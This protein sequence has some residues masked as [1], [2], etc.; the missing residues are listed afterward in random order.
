[1]SMCQSGLSESITFLHFS[2][3]AFNAPALVLFPLLFFR[4]PNRNY[5]GRPCGILERGGS[6][7]TCILFLAPALT[8]CVTLGKSFNF[9]KYT[10]ATG[11]HAMKENT[12]CSESMQESSNEFLLDTSRKKLIIGAELCWDKKIRWP[13]QSL[14]GSVR[15]PQSHMHSKTPRGQKGKGRLKKKKKRI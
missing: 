14:L 15:S 9:S 12:G 4:H 8:N 13:H 10:Y 5:L 11:L 7:N 1:M 6:Q 3:V 2:S